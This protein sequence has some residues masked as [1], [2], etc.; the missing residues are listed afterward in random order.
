M[1]TRPR[2]QANFA[3]SRNF[4]SVAPSIVKNPEM[5]FGNRNPPLSPPSLVFR[6]LPVFL[7]SGILRNCCVS[8]SWATS[9]AR[10]RGEPEPPET[11]PRKRLRRRLG[12]SFPRVRS[13]IRRPVR[14]E[15]RR[16]LRRT[17]PRQASGPR[18]SHRALPGLPPAAL[19]RRP[20]IH[21][22]IQ[23]ELDAQAHLSAQSPPP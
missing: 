13:P 10:L 19:K 2:R 6:S 1:P 3:K 18:G 15:P 14:S 8:G 22:L 21:L 7:P 17:V 23:D 12:G 11:S 9:G 16:R 4:P 5:G 20:G